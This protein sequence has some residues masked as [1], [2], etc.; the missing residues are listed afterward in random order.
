MDSRGKADCGAKPSEASPSGLPQPSSQPPKC[1]EC[2][3]SRVWRDGLRYLSSGRIVQRWLCRLCGYRFSKPN[4]EVDVG[5]QFGE[6]FETVKELPHAG[7][8]ASDLSLKK[9][10]NETSFKGGEDA[11]IHN[12]TILAKTINIF[13]DYTR[14]CRVC[15]SESG[16][17][18]SA[19]A[20]KAPMEEK[21]YAE[22][23]AA[24][25]TANIQEKILEFLWW[26]K[27]QGYRESTI[28]SRGRKLRRLVKLGANLLDPESVK[29]IIARQKCSDSTKEALVCAYDLFVKWLG[30]KWEK[31]T[32]KRIQKMPFIPLEREK[33]TI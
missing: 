3:S 10:L 21:A 20:V 13:R 4:V 18:N 25:A 29:D 17:K 22:S 32:Y 24:G 31:P 16:A 23:R 26:M 14:D 33:W 9:P 12:E 27:K 7:I 8:A 6:G 30:I 5:G 2:G 1:P 11:G 19:G 15:A 28:E